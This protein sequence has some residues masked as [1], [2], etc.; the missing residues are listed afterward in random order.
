[1]TTFAQALKAALERVTERTWRDQLDALHGQ[2]G[3]WKATA[4]ALDVTPRTL[5]RWRNGYLNRRGVRIHVAPQG[6]MAKVRAAV[7]GDRRVQAAAVDW[8]RLRI[9]GTIELEHNPKYRRRENMHVGQYLS[10]DAIAG[11]VAAYVSRQ[12]TR[13]QRAID[14]ALSE[15]YVANG[16]T[17]LLDVDELDFGQ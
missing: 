14:D 2:H 12:A 15:E 8:S 4:A 6:P 17:R 16:D 9:K 10:G 5:E 3:T 11:L 7:K 1:V 13:M